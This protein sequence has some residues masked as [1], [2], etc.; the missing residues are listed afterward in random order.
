MQFSPLWLR[1]FSETLPESVET[2]LDVA[3]AELA[4]F[5]E[6][7]DTLIL[8]PALGESFMYADGT[9]RGGETG[10]LYGAYQRIFAH[11]LHGELVPGTQ[12]PD[13]SLRMLN[14]WDNLDGSVERGYA[15]RSIFF[16][17]G[18]LSYD[19]ARIRMLGRLMAS[20]GLN[21]ICINNVNVL[22]EAQ[23]LMEDLLPEVAALAALLRPF[24]VRLMLS[25]DFALP[26]R[27]GV[28]TADPLAPEVLAFWQT[29]CDRI[30]EAIP[31][32]A[33]FVVKADSEHRPGPFTYGRTHADGA[34]MLADAVRAHGGV[35]VWRA[36]V[37]NC[38]QDWRDTKTD[39]PK[40]ALDTYLPLDGAFRDN[41]ILQVKHG[42]FDFQV[43]EPISPTLLRMAH[44][45]LAVEFQ[46]TQE[47]TGHQKDIYAMPELFLEVFDALQCAPGSIPAVAAVANFGR[48]HCLTGHPFAAL[49]FFAY[50]VFAWK[51]CN[52]PEDVTEGYLRLAYPELSFEQRDVL[53]ELLMHSRTVYEHYTAPLGLCWMVV[54]GLHYGPSPDGYEYQAWGTYHR[55]DRNAVGIDRTGSGT[56]YL[57]QYPEDI[58]K[59]YASPETCPDNLLLFFHRL[60]YTFV[61]K[62]GRTLIQRIFDDHFLGVKE[63][64]HMASALEKIG[65]ALPADD[66]DL[67]LSRMQLQLANSREWCDVINTFFHRLS[68]IDDLHGRTIYA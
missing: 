14:C 48:D 56:G 26:L 11:L 43:R 59:Q 36:F 30:W 19:P 38:M 5:P 37:Y 67:I 42:P 55:A 7:K 25:A 3:R 51:K 68:G 39:R 29:T 45:R 31:D 57:L 50:G 61:M 46:L 2:P 63:T 10:V 16:E 62:D 34:N 1:S 58:Q 27:H 24:G 13:F 12:S 54:P 33:G 65:D 41:V 28:S 53:R 23:R 32:F 6:I 44:T 4:H 9:I 60:P 49:N 52:Q 20:V 22:F 8:D 64:E 66:R 15:G 40:A 47:Y 35:I 18:R 17:S 21:V